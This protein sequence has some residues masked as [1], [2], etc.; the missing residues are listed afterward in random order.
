M[1][2]FVA[3]HYLDLDLVKGLAIVHTNDATDHLRD[4]NHVAEVGPH[5]LRLLTGR[6]LKLLQD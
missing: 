4:N 6:C 5:R 2:R 1:K 3:N